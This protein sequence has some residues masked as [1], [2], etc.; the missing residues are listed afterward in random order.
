MSAR[1]QALLEAEVLLA[2]ILGMNREYL[3]SHGEEIVEEADEKLFLSYVRR[4]LNGEPLA[5]IIH[6]KEFFGLDFYV[7]ERV[8]V[9]RP[10]TEAIVEEI[11]NYLNNDFERS[12]GFRMLDIGTGSGNIPV[13]V[14]HATVDSGGRIDSIDAI[15]KSEEALEVAKINVSQYNLDD[16]ISLFQSDLLENIGSMESYDVISANL[17]YIGEE[18]Y[19][20]VDENVEKYEPAQALFGGRDGL[21]IYRRLCAEMTEKEIEFEIFLGEFGFGQ[22]E[23]V[24]KLLEEFFPGKWS[25]KKDLA[26]IDRM[27]II[28]N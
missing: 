23:D 14:T 12:G 7:D 10:E 15:D 21:E 22:A 1:N 13:A 6:K 11:L 2:E 9:P 17:P 28:K 3:L 18:I 16:K 5:Y 20:N 26:G 4:I 19:R 24:G 27:F 25:I 8:L